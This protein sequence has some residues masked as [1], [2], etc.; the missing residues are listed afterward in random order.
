MFVSSVVQK[1][2]EYELGN[3]V[4]LDW[5]NRW[6]DRRRVVRRNGR[7]V[8]LPEVSPKK[9]ESRHKTQKHQW[10]IDAE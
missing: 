3:L 7:F 9:Q 1:D 2:Y 8:S 10:S 6:P 4:F 5:S